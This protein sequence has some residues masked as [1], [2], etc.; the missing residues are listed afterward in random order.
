MSVPWK[1]CY[2]MP[3]LPKVNCY[4]SWCLYAVSATQIARKSHYAGDQELVPLIGTRHYLLTAQYEQPAHF[5]CLYDFDCSTNSNIVSHMT[6]HPSHTSPA[7]DLAGLLD[8]AFFLAQHGHTEHSATF[9]QLAES[10]AK[11]HDSEEAQLAP[12]RI[13]FAR[14]K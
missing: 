1:S 4:C 14:S 11:R 9:V 12:W 10:L 8:D 5:C 6:Y 3:E 13:V 7:T 2:H